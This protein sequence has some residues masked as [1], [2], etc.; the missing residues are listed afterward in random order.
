MGNIHGSII[1]NLQT[2]FLQIHAHNLRLFCLEQP[3][4]IT[5]ECNGQESFLQRNVKVFLSCTTSRSV[6]NNFLQIISI[7]KFL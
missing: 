5:F 4:F 1:G 2:L 7:T 6:K 3:N